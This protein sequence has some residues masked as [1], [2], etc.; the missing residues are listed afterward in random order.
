MARITII[1]CGHVGLVVA[2]GLA[3][4]EHDVIGLDVDELLVHRL[5][6]GHVDIHEPGLELL[7]A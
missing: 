5:R 1:G 7:V 6:N 4:L 3:A 2:A